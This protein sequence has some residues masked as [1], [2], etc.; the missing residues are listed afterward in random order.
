[1]YL[2]IFILFVYR[3]SNHIIDEYFEAINEL[4]AYNEFV[5]DYNIVYNLTK[6][7]K[8]FKNTNKEM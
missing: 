2:S 1:M 7:I 4:L 8:K 3:K 6:D 5:I